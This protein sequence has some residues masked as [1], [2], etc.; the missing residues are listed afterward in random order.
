VDD[1]EL[2][3]WE[4]LRAWW[5]IYWP[6]QLLLGALMI[7]SNAAL[8]AFINY[9]RAVNPLS[10]AL[11]VRPALAFGLLQVAASA[12]AQYAFVVRVVSRPFRG[13]RLVVVT[14]DAPCS[15]VLTRAMRGRVW[16]FLWWRQLVAGLLAMLLLVPLNIVLMTMGIGISGQLATLAGVFAVGPIL[17]KMLIGHSFPTFRIEVRRDLTRQSILPQPDSQ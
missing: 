3:Y 15:A 7:L 14:P 13:F 16:F 12:V 9:R 2:S 1:L 8:L 11:P 10:P 4:A 6:T 17:V 5:R